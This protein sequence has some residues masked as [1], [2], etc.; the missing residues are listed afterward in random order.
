MARFFIDRPIFAWV[1]AILM[2]LAAVFALRH[3]MARRLVAHR[4]WALRLFLLASGVWF[5]RVGLM[6]WIAVNGGPVGFDPATFQGPALDAISF[7]QYVLP[8]ALLQLYFIA[9]E[10]ASARLRIATAGVLTLFTCAMA[11]GIVVA[12][13]GMW[14]P[15]MR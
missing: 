7:L 2:M 10:S 14:L 8:L 11:V 13:M 5:F 3:A 6:F 9:K 12:T 4:R 1:L 15:N